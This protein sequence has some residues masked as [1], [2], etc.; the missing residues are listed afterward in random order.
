LYGRR[1][2]LSDEEAD[3]A[4]LVKSVVP[5]WEVLANDKVG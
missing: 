3:S 1:S 4:V 5:A 2:D